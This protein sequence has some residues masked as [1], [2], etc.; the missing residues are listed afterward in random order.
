MI[1]WKYLLKIYTLSPKF[2][3]LILWIVMN[4][5][6]PLPCDNVS[7]R[8]TNNK[9]NDKDYLGNQTMIL[10]TGRWGESSFYLMQ[11]LQTET[12]FRLL[13]L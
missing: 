6:N 13:Y 8:D 2:Y 3:Y 9:C 10:N 11:T 4:H 1:N 12:D 7:H 5:Q